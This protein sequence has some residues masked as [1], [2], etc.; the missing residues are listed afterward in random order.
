MFVVLMFIVLSSLFLIIL[1]HILIVT[2]IFHSGQGSV[3][4]FAANR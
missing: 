4:V 3:M 2:H 1:A